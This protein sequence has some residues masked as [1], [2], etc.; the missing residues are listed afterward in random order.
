[1]RKHYTF[2]Q[3]ASCFLVDLVALGFIP[4]RPF[5]RWGL[6]FAYLLLITIGVQTSFHLSTLLRHVTGQNISRIILACIVLIPLLAMTLAWDHAAMIWL[7]NLSLSFFIILG[8]VTL[9]V[10]GLSL[11][12]QTP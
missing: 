3:N 10:Y 9:L 1:M 12:P 5:L 2:A 11:E 7:I 6:N 8:A 4:D